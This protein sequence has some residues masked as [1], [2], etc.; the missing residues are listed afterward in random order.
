MQYIKIKELAQ[1]IP[2]SRATIWRMA[3]DGRLPRPIRFSDRCTAWRKA[4]IDKWL[5][6]RERAA[7]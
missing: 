4:D 2:V 1:M 6:D 3:T 7:V 5:A